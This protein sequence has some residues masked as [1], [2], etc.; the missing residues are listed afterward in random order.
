MVFV[1]FKDVKC[2]SW[3]ETAEKL[4]E[5]LGSEFA[6]HSEL[7]NSPSRNDMD[8]AFFRRIMERGT[9]VEELS[10]ALLTLTKMLHEHHKVAPIII[11]DEYDTPIQQGHMRGFYEQVILFMRN[12]F[13]GGF[14]DNRHLSFGFLTGI[15]RVANESTG[16]I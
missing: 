2:E 12:L 16:A 10:G 4:A 11:I 13:S 8:K 6:R 15:L 1:T 3:E 5:I 14:K 7:L 9:S